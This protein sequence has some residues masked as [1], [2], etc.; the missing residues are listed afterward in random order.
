MSDQSIQ[1]DVLDAVVAALGGDTGH[2]YRCRFTPFAADELPA[3]NVLPEDET[4]NY[5]VTTGEVELV[6]RFMVRHIAQAANLVDKAVDL[7]YA[8]AQKLILADPT[9]GGLV[10]TTRYVGR[11]WEME[12]GEYDN[13]AL[14]VTYEVEFSTSRRDPTVAGS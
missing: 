2:T 5:G 6:H 11:K 12:K 14:V 13:V 4:A 10:R 8:A 9:L 3:D 7:R 1:S